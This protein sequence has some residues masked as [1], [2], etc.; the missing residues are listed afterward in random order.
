[1]SIKR[2]MS[3]NGIDH[4]Y[5]IVLEVIKSFQGNKMSVK[6]YSYLKKKKRGDFFSVHDTEALIPFFSL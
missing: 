4:V 6:T 3:Y 5:Y 2:H 1:M